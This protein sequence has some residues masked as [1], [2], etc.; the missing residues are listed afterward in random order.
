ME[1]ESGKKYLVTTDSWFFAPDG[2]EYRAVFGTAKA[3]HSAESALG[4]KTN[5]RSTNWYATIGNIL[6]AGC[7]IHYVVQ[8]DEVSDKPPMREI[9]FEGKLTTPDHPKTRIYMADEG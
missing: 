6:I 8:T 3:V 2:E 4:I 7:Q 5:A 9:V 1:L